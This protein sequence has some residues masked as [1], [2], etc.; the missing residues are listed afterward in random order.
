MR[1]FV[2]V[3]VIPALTGYNVGK[4]IMFLHTEAS[5]RKIAQLL[6]YMMGSPGG[7]R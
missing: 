6:S 1:I 7:Q 5:D 4:R 2:F 3:A